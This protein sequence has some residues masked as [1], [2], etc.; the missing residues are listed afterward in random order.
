VIA[1]DGGVETL[2]R[3]GIAPDHVV[4]DLDSA[5]ERALQWAVKKSA[6]VHRRP[7]P[8]KPD[9]A[10]GLDLCKRLRCRSVVVVGITG[11]RVDHVL[12]A[13]H[14]A[15]AARGLQFTVVT[16]EVVLFPLR[17][18]V[19]RSLSVPHGHTLSWFGFP[20]AQSCTLSGVRWPFARR[21]LSVDGFH[22]LSNEPKAKTVRLQQGSG[23]SLFIV[24]LHP[25]TLP[26]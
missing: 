25:K 7:S 20:Q 5:A 10:K 12:G 26:R 4:G 23:R 14:F 24:S 6:R 1:L 9:L 3:S 18:R 17:G 13:L 19:R 22:S 2:F 21:K 11:E 16:N 8:D 15:L